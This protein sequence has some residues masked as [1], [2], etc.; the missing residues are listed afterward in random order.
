[1]VLNVGGIS[2]L[3]G[4]IAMAADVEGLYA[5]VKALVCVVRSNKNAQREMTRTDGYKVM[6]LSRQF[7][8]F[9]VSTCKN[10][11]TK[12]SCKKMHPSF[13]FEKLVL[14][15]KKK[16]KKYPEKLPFLKIPTFEII[17]WH[18]RCCFISENY[19]L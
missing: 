3:L 17:F 15:L 14:Y 1:M 6:F 9:T 4:L 5:A 16:K 13:Q 8:R 7:H 2:A 10:L 12:R 11:R 19:M 18:Q